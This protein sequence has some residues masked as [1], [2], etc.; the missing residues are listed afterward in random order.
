MLRKAY[1]SYVIKDRIKSRADRYVEVLEEFKKNAH[2]LPAVGTKE[3]GVLMWYLCETNF[4]T[5]PMTYIGS[6]PSFSGCAFVM[7]RSYDM[8]TTAKRHHDIVLDMI[9]FCIDYMRKKGVSDEYIFGYYLESSDGEDVKLNAIKDFVLHPELTVR[10]ST[11]YHFQDYEKQYA[12]VLEAV[13]AAIQS[14]KKPDTSFS[15]PP[16]DA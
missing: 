9:K 8:D 16:S 13:S 4:Y 15:Y 12:N 2:T 3:Y 1:N 6:E 10:Q 7:F 11:V 5:P 14:V